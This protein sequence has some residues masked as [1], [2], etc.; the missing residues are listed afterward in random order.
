M[1]KPTSTKPSKRIVPAWRFAQE[2]T[3]KARRPAKAARSDRR[4]AERQIRNALLEA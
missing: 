4:S 2:D 1:M 3:M